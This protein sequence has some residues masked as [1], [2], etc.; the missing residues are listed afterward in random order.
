ALFPVIL[1]VARARVAK[2]HD[3]PLLGNG[4]EQVRLKA[5][6]LDLARSPADRGADEAGNELVDEPAHLRLFLWAAIDRH[7]RGHVG[8]H[9]RR[10]YQAFVIA[11]GHDRRADESRAHAPARREGVLL[12]LLA[13]EELDVERLGEVLTEVMAR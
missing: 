6:P 5:M 11:V 7:N 9:A 2:V 13:A 12:L 1:L 10:Q 4:I 3:N 8:R